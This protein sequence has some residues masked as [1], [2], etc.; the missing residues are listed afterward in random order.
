MMADPIQSLWASV[1][2]TVYAIELTDRR[3]YLHVDA[4][5]PQ[6]MKIAS[7][8]AA[9]ACALFSETHPAPVGKPG[10]DLVMIGAGIEGIRVA[11]LVIGDVL[12]GIAEN[13]R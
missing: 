8:E 4:A 7:E 2:S 3:K 6:A 9:R 5:S 1:F 11:L 12:Q 10:I 13:Q